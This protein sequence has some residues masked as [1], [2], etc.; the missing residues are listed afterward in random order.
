MNST[1][2]QII[3]DRAP[4]DPWWDT[5]ESKV[6]GKYGKLFHPDNLDNLTKE[7]FKSFL[8]IKNNLGGK[9]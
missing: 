2:T 4:K 8:L 1:I 6:V 3:K 7:D 9:T 5:S